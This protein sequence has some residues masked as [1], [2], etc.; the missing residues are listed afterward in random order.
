[1]TDNKHLSI[2]RSNRL[3]M[4]CRT[5]SV[6]LFYRFCVCQCGHLSR[7]YGDILAVSYGTARYRTRTAAKANR[8][9]WCYLVGLA[10]SWVS[11]LAYQCWLATSIWR[12]DFMWY[13]LYHEFVYWWACLCGAWSCHLTND[14]HYFRSLLWVCWGIFTSRKSYQPKRWHSKLTNPWW[15]Y[16][17]SLNYLPKGIVTINKIYKW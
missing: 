9:G 3:N 10:S 4:T 2:H 1:M 6:L 16:L 17:Y 8:L 5:Q 14:W 11:Q 12:G 7:W 13:W 15:P